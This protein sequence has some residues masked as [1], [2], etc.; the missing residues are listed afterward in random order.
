MKTFIT[1]DFLLYNDTAKELFHGTA[2]DLPIIDYHNHLNQKEI[3]E[4]KNFTNLSEIWLGG[5]HYKWR[6]M[7]A[8]GVDESFITGDKSDYEKFLEWSKTVPKTFGNPLY[9]W[10]HLELKH[11]FGID[12]LLN[13]KICTCNLGRSK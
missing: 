1:D 6:A 3:L 7:R 12:E 8:N 5:D 4:D 13:E 9:H 11:Y 2:K 10:T